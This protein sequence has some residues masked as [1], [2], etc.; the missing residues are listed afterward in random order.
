MRPNNLDEFLGQEHIVGQGKLLR[1]AIQADMLTSSIFFGPPGC[2][3]TTLAHVIANT[4]S[5]S[6]EK[7]NAV[8]SGVADVRKNNKEL[9]TGKRCTV[10]QHI[11]YW[12][13]AT[14][15]P[16]PSPTVYYQL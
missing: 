1:R 4:T 15:G 14:D 2:G 10:N 7:L 12:M 16:N 8:T 3:K 9:T 13:S 11:C 5:S 6:F